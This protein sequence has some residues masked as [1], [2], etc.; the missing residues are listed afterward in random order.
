MFFCVLRV[1]C[2]LIFPMYSGREHEPR[3][4][5]TRIYYSEFARLRRLTTLTHGSSVN[6][7]EI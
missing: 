3:G 1:I 6:G 5:E 7:R 2:G 4:G